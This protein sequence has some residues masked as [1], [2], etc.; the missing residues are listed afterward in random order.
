MK[1]KDRMKKI[2]TWV[3][4][5]MEEYGVNLGVV[6]SLGLMMGGFL[7]WGSYEGRK[8]ESA[9]RVAE[10]ESAVVASA[11]P[12]GAAWKDHFG[13]C[14]GGDE[15]KVASLERLRVMAEGGDA[16]AWTCLGLCH[17]FG[18]GTET[19][20]AEAVRCWRKAAEGG[21]ERGAALLGDALYGGRGT[22]ADVREAKRWLLAAWERG[23]WTAPFILA[24][25]TKRR[26]SA[27]WAMRGVELCVQDGKLKELVWRVRNALEA[28]EVAQLELGLLLLEGGIQFSVSW[29]GGEYVIKREGTNLGGLLLEDLADRGRLQDGW[30]WS[31]IGLTPTVNEEWR[32]RMLG[33][34][35]EGLEGGAETVRDWVEYGLRQGLLGMKPYGYG[36][37][38]VGQPLRWTRKLAADGDREAMKALVCARENGV[39]EGGCD[40]FE[41][42]RWLLE[43]SDEAWAQYRMGCRYATGERGLDANPEKAADWFA[44]CRDQDSAGENG[45]TG[46]NHA[47]LLYWLRGEGIDWVSQDGEDGEWAKLG[48]VLAE[49]AEEIAGD[50]EGRAFYAPLLLAVKGL[51]EGDAEGALGWLEEADP[52]LVGGLLAEWEAIVGNGVEDEGTD[53]AFVRGARLL[54]GVGGVPDWRGAVEAFAEAAEGGNQKARRLACAL[55]AIEWWEGHDE[56]RAAELLR[57]G[58]KATDVW[59]VA[60]ICGF[61]LGKCWWRKTAEEWEQI[62]GDWEDC[63]VVESA[64]KAIM[65]D[66][67]QERARADE[68]L[69]GPATR[70]TIAEWKELWT[71]YCNRGRRASVTIEPAEEETAAGAAESGA[72]SEAGE[73][74]VGA[75]EGD[76]AVADVAEA[77]EVQAPES[78]EEGNTGGDAGILE[79]E[80]TGLEESDGAERNVEEEETIGDAEDGGGEL[81]ETGAGE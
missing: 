38:E 9:R 20:Q 24:D 13:A 62:I 49:R 40:V 15:E 61:L 52:A 77:Q 10:S 22:K 7:Y 36:V 5:K 31:W 48:G 79:P 26:E 25:M 39:E 21:D 55:L 8:E 44:K 43:V 57:A 51:R 71:E 37:G 34:R 33:K 47:L 72:A 53:E 14:R 30:A 76:V 68:L 16:E 69:D 28:N 75:D 59:C 3:R 78:G 58:A 41:E 1:M 18:V 17:S 66:K 45:G 11:E 32:A 64:M 70:E 50:G 65:E 60:R 19:N 35:P 46:A 23:D 29:G 12:E 74:E 67:L 6:L 73:T 80:N 27:I 63:P 81:A 2:G 4:R 54:L 42:G 56:A